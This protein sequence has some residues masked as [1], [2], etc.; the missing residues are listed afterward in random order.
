[1]VCLHSKFSRPCFVTRLSL[2]T[3]P[4]QAVLQIKQNIL[5]CSQ[6]T[7]THAG[8]EAGFCHSPGELPII[9]H[10]TFTRTDRGDAV[11]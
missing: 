1:M 11:M 2:T 4:V 3:L 8:H 9:Y 6:L 7:A 10:H 5:S